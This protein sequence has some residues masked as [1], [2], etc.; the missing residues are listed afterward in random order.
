MQVYSC[1]N[2]CE[3][4]QYRKFSFTIKIDRK[5]FCE[6]DHR[7]GMNECTVMYLFHAT[8]HALMYHD[9]Y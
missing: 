8:V 6:K 7:S 4:E 1:K 5:N 9:S 2:F 3:K